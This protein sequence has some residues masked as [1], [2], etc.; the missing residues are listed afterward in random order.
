ML[1]Q[2]R[3]HTISSNSSASDVQVPDYF[4]RL[5]DFKQMDFEATFDQVIYLLSSDPERA[6]KNFYYRKRKYFSL[7]SVIFI[8]SIIV[9]L[10]TANGILI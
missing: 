1:P 3:I 7:Q 8:A 4:R 6:F 5:I 2:S 10:S 9:Y